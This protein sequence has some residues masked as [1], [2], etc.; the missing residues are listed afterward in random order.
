MKPNS[1]SSPFC[2]LLEGQDDRHVIQHLWE[3]EHKEKSPFCILDKDGV[4]GLIE[5]IPN[6]IKAPSREVL[7]IVVDA[8]GNL[9]EC[10]KKITRKIKEGLKD[11]EVKQV[12]ISDCP[13]PTGTIIDCKVIS[14]GIWLMPNNKA[15]GELE[16]FIVEMLPKNDL[17]WL[18]AK[19]YIQ[20]IPKEDRK[21]NDTKIEKKLNFLHGLQQERSLDVWA[22]PLV[23]VI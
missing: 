22:Q 3:K 8:N 1:N 15:C 10:W 19:R 16:N 14:I 21:F 17:I 5:A 13:I 4:N 2:L 12:Q 9:D 20:N 6:E 23:L 18:S 11:L 7:G